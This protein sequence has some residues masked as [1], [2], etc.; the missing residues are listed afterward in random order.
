MRNRTFLAL[1]VAAASLIAVT[2]IAVFPSSGAAGP[3]LEPTAGRGELVHATVRHYAETLGVD[4]PQLTLTKFPVSARAFYEPGRIGLPPE[5]LDESGPYSE[6]DLRA[7]LAHEMVHIQHLD[8]YWAPVQGLWGLGLDLERRADEE[9]A[10][11][12]GCQKMA[13][14]FRRHPGKVAAG[15]ANTDDPHPPLTERVEAAMRGCADA[16]AG[17]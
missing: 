13:D 15:A 7:I 12:V 11:L 6:D 3:P 9:G 4:V 14:L 17:A 2:Y 16:V 10:R 8:S 1:Y 5:S